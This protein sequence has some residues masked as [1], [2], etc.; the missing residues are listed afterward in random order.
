MIELFFKYDTLNMCAILIFIASA[1]LNV[2]SNVVR[3]SLTYFSALV[4]RREL[5]FG[6]HIRWFDALNITVWIFLFVTLE[7]GNLA[8]N[9]TLIKKNSSLNAVPVNQIGHVWAF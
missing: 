3:P 6:T 7:S 4:A 5:K 9:R 1:V 2:L 8:F